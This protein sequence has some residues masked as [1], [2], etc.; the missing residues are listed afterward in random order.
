MPD[1]QGMFSTQKNPNRKCVII[2]KKKKTT[3][4][5]V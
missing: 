5:C 2:L 3:V 1:E 4:G